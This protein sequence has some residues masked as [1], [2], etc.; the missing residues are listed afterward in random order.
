MKFT[1]AFFIMAV[2]FFLPY[3]TGAEEVHDVCFAYFTGSDCVNCAVADS[4][5]FNEILKEYNDTLLVLV[6]NVNDTESDQIMDEYSQNYGIFRAIPTAVFAVHDFF[7]SM[8][9]IKAGLKDRIDYFA[10]KEG[11]ECPM[12]DGTT[13]PVAELRKEVVSVPPEMVGNGGKFG[14]DGGNAGGNE[15]PGRP[16]EEPGT[17]GGPGSSGNIMISG[18]ENLI[19]SFSYE[20]LAVFTASTVFVILLVCFIFMRRKKGAQK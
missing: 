15:E 20:T 18:V 5:V 13:K 7:G 12:P 9:D 16:Q 2:L 3:Q 10:T 6:Y 14:V 17:E 19:K 11:N 1:A 8:D 4:Y